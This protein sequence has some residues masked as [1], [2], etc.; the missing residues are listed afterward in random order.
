LDSKSPHFLHVSTVKL[1]R[2][3]KTILLGSPPADILNLFSMAVLVVGIFILPVLGFEDQE[4]MKQAFGF[5]MLLYLGY[6]FALAGHYALYNKDSR[7]FDRYFPQQERVVIA[8]IA[9][10]AMTYV[11]IA[12]IK[13][14]LA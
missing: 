6:A 1:G 7:R 8:I 5:A 14:V 12:I 4:F 10:L 13:N 9:V 2:G 11:I 3:N